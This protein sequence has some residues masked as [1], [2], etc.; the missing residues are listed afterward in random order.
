MAVPIAGMEPLQ[1]LKM[2]GDLRPTTASHLISCETL[3]NEFAGPDNKKYLHVV[4][5]S[6]KLNVYNQSVE[7]ALPPQW[8][9]VIEQLIFLNPTDLGSDCKETMGRWVIYE[10]IQQ[11]KFPQEM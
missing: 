9:R 5:T 11:I 4:E 3:P 6:F 8:G 2:Q 1:A 7:R 10:G